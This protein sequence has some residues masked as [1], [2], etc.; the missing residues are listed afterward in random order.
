MPVKLMQSY[1]GGKVSNEKGILKGTE[2]A[3]CL[4]KMETKR[5]KKNWLSPKYNM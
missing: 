2:K 3:S 5:G 4:I 1:L